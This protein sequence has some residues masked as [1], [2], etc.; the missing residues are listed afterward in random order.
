MESRSNEN[1]PRWYWDICLDQYPALTK[2]CSSNEQLEKVLDAAAEFAIA[3]K[4]A[5]EEG[6]EEP[7]GAG[8]AAAQKYWHQHG[9][10]DEGLLLAMDL[11]CDLTW[12]FVL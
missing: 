12:H 11:G 7:I 1:K 3:A 8:H 5:K 2:V 4:A 6:H 10:D 9:G